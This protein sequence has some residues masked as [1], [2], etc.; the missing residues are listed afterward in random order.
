[1]TQSIE[2]YS[3][4]VIGF[5]FIFMTI[6]IPLSKNLSKKLLHKLGL[7]QKKAK[8]YGED[9]FLTNEIYKNP[10]LGYIEPNENEEPSTVFINSKNSDITT[11][12]KIISVIIQKKYFISIENEKIACHLMTLGF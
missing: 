2:D 12:K 11:L 9:P 8:I 1:M 10:Y 5:S 3:R 7:W 6:L 4:L